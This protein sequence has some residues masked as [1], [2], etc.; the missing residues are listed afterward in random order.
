MKPSTELRRQRARVEAV[1]RRHGASNI[2]LFGSA[3]RGEDTDSSDLDLLVDLASDRSLWDLGE[4]VEDL[5]DL[6]RCEVDVV[7]SDGLNPLLRDRIL[8]E[9]IPL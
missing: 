7:A 6:L 3:A 4:M 2:R 9:A 5:K 8:R 1:A